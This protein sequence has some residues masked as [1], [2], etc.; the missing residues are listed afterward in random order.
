[1]GIDFTESQ[2]QQIF[3]SEAAEDENIERLRSYY[4]K[5]KTF[6][7]V[8]SDLPLR[9]LVGHKGI[10]KSALFQVAMAEDE[11]NN[12]L[13]ILIRPDDIIDLGE[14][15]KDFLKVIRSWKNGLT[16]II[17]RKALDSIGDV[18]GDWKNKLSKQGGKVLKFLHDSF[19]EPTIVNINPARQSVVTRFS[20]RQKIYI[21]IDDLDRGWEGSKEG[22][23]RI[24]A[25]LNAVRDLSNENPGLNF[26][27]S[28]RSDVY[29]LVRTSDE[30]T[31]KIEGS[32]IWYSWTN[33]EI[34]V[35]LVKRVE[36]YFGNEVN[37]QSLLSM[38][39]DMLSKRLHN[40]FEDRFEGRGHWN[41]APM[42]QVILSLLRQ[43]PRDLVKLCSLAA[44]NTRRRRG[45]TINTKDLEDSFEEYSQGRLQDTVNEYKSELPEIE[46]LLLAMKPSKREKKASLSYLF[47][48]DQLLKKI[49]DIQSQGDFRFTSG[50]IASNK[51]LAAF[52]YKVNFLTARKDLGGHIDRKYFENNRYLANRFV[53][54]GYDW[55]VH[56]AFRW[57]LQPDDFREVLESL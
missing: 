5:S 12:N 41:K 6:E 28:L 11:E 16:E 42:H 25:L 30:S 56:P 36:T 57:A 40:I 43:R 20:K 53:D 21:Y 51:D 23:R 32:V 22:V 27:I 55:E 49:A 24:S 26:R 18:E 39:Q 46:R 31:D 50:Y 52:L 7:E 17:A 15:D 4:F 54:F 48:T 45:N 44:R 9:I 34:F 35:M 3:G 2:I 14:D 13:S 10:G 37:E 8:N 38:S 1:M 19:K 33:H 29:F 47:S